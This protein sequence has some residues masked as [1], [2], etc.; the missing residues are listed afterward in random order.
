[1]PDGNQ[2]VVPRIL[3]RSAVEVRRVV[4]LPE[5]WTIDAQKE[6][7]LSD[8]D[9]AKRAEEEDHRAFWSDFLSGH[10]LDDPEQSIPS[11]AKQSHMYLMMPA[12]AG[13]SWITVYH[14]RPTG[15]VGIFLSYQ[16]DTPAERATEA[17]MDRWDDIG[18]QLG[19][20]AHVV[21]RRGRRRIADELH[22]GDTQQA[23]ARGSA[24][25]WLRRRTNDFVNVLRPAI[26]AAVAEVR[27]LD[28]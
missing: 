16:K 18:P 22:V 3:A 21:E 9:P 6:E 17:V 20:Q 1:M 27:E 14:S 11:P 25:E 5:G 13:S 23:D 10:E 24:I 8:V 28:D 12:P 19:G 26:R 4:E 7:E 2:I 15:T